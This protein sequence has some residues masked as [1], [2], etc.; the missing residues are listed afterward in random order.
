MSNTVFISGKCGQFQFGETKWAPKTYRCHLAI[1]CDEDGRF[2]AIVLNL[3][4]AGGDGDTKEDAIANAREAA[5]G[6]IGSYLED[7]LDIPWR[8]STTYAIGDGVE[9]KWIL[10]NA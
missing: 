9:Q 8:D 1:S 5:L 7:G 3:P 10:V 6:V 4:G 2:S